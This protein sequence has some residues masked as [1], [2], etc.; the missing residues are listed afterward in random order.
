[1]MCDIIEFSNDRNPT[2]TWSYLIHQKMIV[3][4]LNIYIFLAHHPPVHQTSPKLRQDETQQSFF[5]VRCFFVE[6]S[7]SSLQDIERWQ[8]HDSRS[9]EDM[10]M[11]QNLP[12]R[13]G[14]GRIKY[15][16]MKIG[17]TNHNEPYKLR[18]NICFNSI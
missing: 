6:R 8:V 11:G 12:E 5:E 9:G 2:D 3:S 18:L 17:N 15:N 1:M 7:A 16:F 14:I 10:G 4:K 13:V